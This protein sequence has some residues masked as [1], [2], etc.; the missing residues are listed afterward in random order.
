MA[1]ICVIRRLGHQ[2]HCREQWLFVSLSCTKRRPCT[3]LML[4]AW[5]SF[6]YLGELG[7][8]T[9][10]AISCTIVVSILMAQAQRLTRQRPPAPSPSHSLFGLEKAVPPE[11]YQAQASATFGHGL[12]A[13][14][15]MPASHSDLEKPLP[16]APQRSSSTY[17]GDSGTSGYTRIVQSYGDDED[18]V[19]PPMPQRPSVRRGTR[20]DLP[21]VRLSPGDRFAPERGHEAQSEP[22]QIEV[23]FRLDNQACRMPH[24][25]ESPAHKAPTFQ[26]F[27]SRLQHKQWDSL[28]PVSADF[29]HRHTRDSVVSSVSPTSA[30]PLSPYQSRL[31]RYTVD[32]HLPGPVSARIADVVDVS[33]VPAPLVLSRKS[34]LPT[35]SRRSSEDSEMIR[36]AL[37]NAPMIPAKRL[38]QDSFTDDSFIIYS[39]AREV[40]KAMLKQAFRRKRK[41]IKEEREKD[42]T[43]SFAAERIP[44]MTAMPNGDSRSKR[45]NHSWVSGR[46]RSS[47]RHGVTNLLRKLSVVD[48]STLDTIPPKKPRREKQR[49]VSPTPY[50]RYGTD[51]WLAKNKKIRAKRRA[52]RIA[53]EVAAAEPPF[54]SELPVAP[55]MSLRHKHRSSAIKHTADGFV[56]ALQGGRSQLVQ[57]LED[58]REALGRSNSERRRQRL[59]GSIKLVGPTEIEDESVHTWV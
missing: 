1:P 52:E 34:P 18:D 22:L 37:R 30:L 31:E 49:A 57:A 53:R 24:T 27:T 14:T 50:Q 21:L 46:R 25:T 44:G 56:H 15:P 12:R 13:Y 55:A 9:A 26:Q 10:A 41:P 11:G 51:I 8:T 20:T 36:A 42:R 39:G 4:S 2:R 45:R 17:S 19:I 38:S 48:R 29:S 5:K 47:V 28:S 40:A 23:G 54:Q 58:T 6:H 43:L 59:K 33:M 7:A 32:S 3:K 35:S 16:R